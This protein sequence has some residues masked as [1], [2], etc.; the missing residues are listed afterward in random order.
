MHMVANNS[1]RQSGAARPPVPLPRLGGYGKAMHG[2]NMNIARSTWPAVPA[3]NQPR[4]TLSRHSFAMAS[5]TQNAK[6]RAETDKS[7]PQQ[8]TAASE[9]KL[10]K[11]A[12][13]PTSPN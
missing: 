9:L 12:A 10:P 3:C 1:A 2:H 11:P 8:S 5:A 7:I 13:S 4:R 6:E